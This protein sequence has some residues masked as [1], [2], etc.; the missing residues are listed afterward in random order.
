MQDSV[1]CQTGYCTALAIRC[2]FRRSRSGW[3]TILF[4]DA[5][6]ASPQSPR[7][8]WIASIWLGVGL[9]G[10]TQNVMVMRAEGMHHAWMRLFLTL[11]LSWLPWALAT[12]PVL[13][14][15]RQYPPLRLAPLLVHSVACLFIGLVYAA[16][17]AYLELLL[18]PYA[19][20]STPA[21]LHF[22]FD[23][24]YNRLLESLILY[25]CIL[26]VAHMLA[27][28]ERIA[29][30][31]TETARLNEQLSKAQLNALRQ[32]IEPHFLFN[33]LNAIAGLVREERNDA[34]VDMIARLSDL[35]R[36]VLKDSNRQN[37]ALQ[38]EM[39]FVQ[40]Y[41][42][43]QKVRFAER[44]QLS[45]DIPS[46]LST[47]QVPNLILQ[48]IVE[49]AVKHGIAKR[50]EG[51]AIRISAHRNNGMLSISVYNDGPGLPADWE[52]DHAGVGIS[53]VRT[54]LQ[55]LFGDT[56]ELRM[57]NQDTSGVKV[58]ISVPFRQE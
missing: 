6:L 38:E 48:P 35:L 31:Q 52:K 26:L 49:N 27:S 4:M 16:W 32:Q 47:A 28:R 37:V 50:I 1:K 46:E 8:F 2:I 39:E 12:P 40:K 43:I 7:W 19:N 17:D 21:F 24:F 57:Q 9:F 5:M 29:Q 34:A 44:L 30:Q 54:R 13:Y 45:V 53:N 22:W 56:F 36:G 58:L 11:L 18:N 20:P 14:L 3:N 55:T 41:M 42:D 51:G 23:V 33:A 10:A 25:G 15:G